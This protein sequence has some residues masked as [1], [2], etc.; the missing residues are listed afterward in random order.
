[1][2]NKIKV[3]NF[4]HTV[5]IMENNSKQD[6]SILH[7]DCNSFYASV[8][9]VLNPALKNVP[10]AVGG[11]EK[12]RHGIIL[13]KNE[14][15][16]K[17]GV[18]TA[19]PIHMARQK[20]KE[21]VIVPPRH[22]LY[23]K[24]SRRVMEIYKRYTD[25]IEPFGLD[26]AWLDI[27]GS[28]RLFGD[29]V[30][31]ADTLRSEVRKETGLTISVGVSFCKVFAKLGSDYKKPDATTVFDRDNWQRL[32]FPMNVNNLLYV[33]KS[34]ERVLNRLAIKTIG[35]LAAAD[36]NLLISHLGKAGRQLHIYA[37]GLD[38]D[39][40]KSVY[41]VDE[42]KSVGKGHTFDHDISGEEEIRH[43]IRP[44]CDSIARRMRAHG[45]KCST[46]QVQIK[47]PKFRVIQRQKKL[48]K[49]TYISREIHEKAM[50]IIRESWNLK[51]PVRMIT[52]TGASLV[53]EN[54]VNEQLSLFDEPD[55]HRQK[56][57][58]LEKTL[59]G[60]KNRFGKDIFKIRSDLEND[61]S[62]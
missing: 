7:C 28:R 4:N 9:S 61:A 56:A 57:E 48:G 60:I 29:A 44:L 53:G 14:L 2:Y 20:C 45:V 8:E 12:D 38:T 3:I 43:A 58:A 34:T 23:R 50:E 22:E 1:M 25:L 49:P 59:D 32:I 6:R 33:G 26:E 37:N 27:T 46:V 18:V 5:S 47:D 19:E 24:Y 41:H 42:V 51:L 31:I 35:D 21:L 16:K 54:D 55:E 52:I 36:E 15:A 13:A 30:T 10:M 11:S 39:E 62:K 17:Y 40:V